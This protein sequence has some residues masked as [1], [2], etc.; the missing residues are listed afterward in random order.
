MRELREGLGLDLP[1]SLKEIALAI[2]DQ[3]Y[4]QMAKRCHPDVGGSHEQMV[5]LAKVRD[6]MVHTYDR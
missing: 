1:E 4:K 5:T 3:G 6:I 2:I